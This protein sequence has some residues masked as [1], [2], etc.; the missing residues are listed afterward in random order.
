MG[1]Y[2]SQKISEAE[3][4]KVKE[5]N[6]VSDFIMQTTDYYISESLLFN[7][8]YLQ[9]ISLYNAAA[10]VLDLNAY[11]YVLNPYNTKN[12][13]YTK[14]PAQIRNYSII[15]P[16]IKLFV[17]ENDKRPNNG[18]VVVLNADSL[19][20]FKETLNDQ[21]YD[22]LKQQFVNELNQLGVETG[23]ESKPTQSIEQ[24]VQNH[25]TNYNDQRAIQGQEALDYI[26]YNCDLDD[27]YQD[28]FYDWI[29]TGK[30]YT[31]KEVYRN[32]VHF[33]VV[34][35]L[36]MWS[37]RD[38]GTN[39]I[40]NDSA[41]VRKFR[42]SPSVVIDRFRDKLTSENIDF[43]DQLKNG[44]NATEIIVP[45]VVLVNNGNL[46]GI[47]NPM[48]PQNALLNNGLVDIF[49]VT[50]KTFKRIGIL[51][52]KDELGAIQ[53]KE[54]D[55]TYKL[56]KE[57]GDI[58]IDWQYINQYC[59]SWRVDRNIYLGGNPLIVQRD[60]LNNSSICKGCYNGRINIDRLGNIDS[61]VKS[62]LNYEVLHNIYHYR[63]ERT[64]AKNKD[65]IL[66]L[67]IGMIP[68]K[69]EMDKFMYEVDA[70]GIAWF[71][72]TKPNAV[73]VLQSIRTVNAGLAAY[74]KDMIFF[75]NSIKQEYWE[76]VGVNAQRYGDVSASEGKG[77]V[78]QAI[79]RS[80][81]I[82]NEEFRKF[83][84]FKEK[85]N[86]GLLDYSKVAW[87]DGKKGMYINSE[88]RRAFLDVDGVEH[89]ETE[90]GVFYKNNSV[91]AQKLNDMKQLAFA[92]VQKTGKMGMSAE[93]I[94]ANNFSKVKDIIKR[95][96]EIEQALIDQAR[97]QELASQEKVAQMNNEAVKIKAESDK[98]KVDK[99]S[100]TKIEV[101]L[102]QADIATM[103]LEGN[104][105]EEANEI[106]G[107]D[108]ETKRLSVIA[109]NR[110]NQ[111]NIENQ[112]LKVASDNFNEMENRKVA[113][114]E[115]QSKEKIAKT[116]KNKYDK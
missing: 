16:I 116:N 102:I 105:N 75:I 89:M 22:T 92:Q 21:I 15:K 86:D 10:G 24:V 68:K 1:V 106:A 29:V 111:A 12:T 77:N 26:K 115:I 23:M 5:G 84:K 48:L 62:G 67:P 88:G 108:S 58:S 11:N 9:D 14:Y 70:S 103:T 78:E 93:V 72:E 60:E 39:F 43:L 32:D 57:L 91:E 13:D 51:I 6:T 73:N 63:L 112:N 71:D 107:Q 59:E 30:V 100:Y 38:S 44:G 90:Y 36:E 34:S 64:L 82:T 76:S 46:D 41:A 81:V 80:A 96:E 61:P 2:P 45:N 42:L 33:Q 99:D 7:D 20:R 65:S 8:E 28:A 79:F 35:P 56:E 101:A 114:E 98:Y 55:E 4:L 94:D 53:E 50:W 110:L 52:Y 97:Q 49:H 19:N 74:A 18:Q 25:K 17:G 109:A 104:S 69:W 47:Q 3:K 83:D 85:D 54:V 113:R 27:K 40:E 87:I 31:Y 37:T 95:G 66:M